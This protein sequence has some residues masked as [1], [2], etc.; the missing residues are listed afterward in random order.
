MDLD[1]KEVSKTKRY[2][3]PEGV[4]SGKEEVPKAKRRC[5]RNRSDLKNKEKVFQRQRED[6][7][8]EEEVS[9]ARIRFQRRRQVFKARKRSR[10][11]EKK[12]WKTRSRFEDEY[13]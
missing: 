7:E 5:R 1:C 9:M 12:C 4:L 13:D 6:L 8:D 10:R 11:R 2:R 3:R